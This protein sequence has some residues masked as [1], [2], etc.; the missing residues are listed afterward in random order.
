MDTVQGHATTLVADLEAE[1]SLI[2]ASQRPLIFVCHGLGGIIVKSALV[3]SAS[4]TSHQTSHLNSIYVSTFAILFF[5][6]PHDRIDIGKWL[7]LRQSGF[8]IY[9]P[10][11]VANMRDDN[12]KPPITLHALD[13]I[14]NQFAP[15]MKKIHLY[16]F[17]EGLATQLA[18]G[19]DFFVEPSS[20]APHTYDTE[21]CGIMDSNHSGMVK[22]HQD[23]TS[24]RTVI[25]AL[26]KYCHSAPEIIAYRWKEA[27]A[28]L[29]RMRKSEASELTGLF[30]DI[31]DKTPLFGE[32]K[33][34]TVEAVL[35]N[36][37]FYPPCAVSLDFIGQD[38]IIGALQ[39]AFE[40]EQNSSFMEKQKRFVLYGIGGSGK[41]QISAKY[42]QDNRKL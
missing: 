24:Y 14:T 5:G 1:R 8:A 15:L 20:A 31:P 2:N 6:T 30:I 34:D 41:T 42:A 4:R 16:L 17:W 3:H 13:V 19:V 25:S 9:D 7:A 32:E 29:T 21:R 33:E 18:D 36:E 35:R 40:P 23:D 38:E 12:A 22:F 39:T 26:K 28:S 10:R 11:A 37:H 27:M